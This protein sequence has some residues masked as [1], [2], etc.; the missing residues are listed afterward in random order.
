[1]ADGSTRNIIELFGH[2]KGGNFKI[3]IWAWL[4]YSIG[5]RREN[6]FYLFGKELINCLSSANVRAFHENSNRFYTEHRFINA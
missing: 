4:G 6:M 3:H 5:S 1:M 2:C